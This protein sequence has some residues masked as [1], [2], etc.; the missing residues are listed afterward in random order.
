MLLSQNRIVVLMGS[1]RNVAILFH[2]SMHQKLASRSQQAQRA[3]PFTIQKIKDIP[4][5]QGTR[6]SPA[7][8]FGERDRLSL[9]NGSRLQ[10]F[11][12]PSQFDRLAARRIETIQEGH[13]CAEEKGPWCPSQLQHFCLVAVSLFIAAYDGHLRR[14]ADE[15]YSF[16]PG[17]A[18]Q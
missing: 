12:R 5:T 3:V 9:A 14:S 13:S 8:A 11:E 4:R 18:A 2:S 17:N 16:G 1:C 6:L 15:R 10:P 7:S